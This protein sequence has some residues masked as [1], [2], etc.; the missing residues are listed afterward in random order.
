M[1][2]YRV[3]DGPLSGSFEQRVAAHLNDG[4]ELVGGLVHDER[5]DRVFQA[6]TRNTDPIPYTVTPAGRARVEGRP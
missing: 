4:W 1:I 3:I 5:R 6:L 2:E